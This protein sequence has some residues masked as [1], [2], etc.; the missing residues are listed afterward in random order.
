M[1][2]FVQ[3]PQITLSNKLF[4]SEKENMESQKSHQNV[5]VMR[6]GDRAD[7]VEP[8]W[9]SSAA[10]PWDPHLVNDGLI[11]AFSTGRKLRTQLGF[12][13]HRVFVSPFLRCIQTASEVVYALCAIDEDPNAMSS[14]EVISIDASRVK[15]SVEYGL[16]EMM[17]RHAIKLEIAPK[18]G[19]F[20]FNIAEAEALLPAGT[21]DHSV[22]RVYEEMPQ[23]EETVSDTRSRYEWIIKA[24]ADK[25][26]SENLLLVS[27]G[28]AVGVAVSAFM[29]EDVSVHE[30]MYCAYTE[31]RR[32]ILSEN[33]S[34][35]AGEF[36]IFSS[37]AQSG[38]SYIPTPMDK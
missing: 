35:T 3:I 23:W 31:L 21:V 2:S 30:V 34:F 14:K 5:V 38:V 36:E 15:V 19:D 26:P 10:R 33:G 6:H 25:Y 29:K 18:D 20:G 28:E 12:P 16:C 7:N 9:V 11:R 4:K 32:P 22:K 37:P 17:N 24:L 27:H 13:I 8:M 1:S